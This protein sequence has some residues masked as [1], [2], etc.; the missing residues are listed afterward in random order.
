MRIP[1]HKKEIPSL[2][3]AALPDLIFTVLFFFMIV[4]HMRETDVKVRYQTPAGTQLKQTDSKIHTLY[5][6][7]GYPSGDTSSQLTVQINNKV[8]PKHQWAYAIAHETA[9]LSSND[10]K[11]VTAVISADK[12]IDM[13]TV[14]DIKH[15]LRKNGV[16]KMLYT[17]TEKEQMTNSLNIENSHQ[18]HNGNVSMVIGPSK[19]YR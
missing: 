7:I 10:N 16:L 18:R 11:D 4:T 6:Y 12:D 2:T 3:T 8:V 15:L 9:L 1:H 19:R 13:G 5:I 14:S 17:A